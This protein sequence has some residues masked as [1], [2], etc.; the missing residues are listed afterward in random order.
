[1]RIT[2]LIYVVQRGVLS[3]AEIQILFGYL[4]GLNVLQHER[5]I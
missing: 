5:N 2:K 1:M 3:S 4:W